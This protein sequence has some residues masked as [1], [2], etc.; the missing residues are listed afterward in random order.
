M[1]RC[2]SWR[3]ARPSDQRP[4]KSR[5]FRPAP[6]CRRHSVQNAAP[7][8]VTLADAT[9][10]ATHARQRRGKPARPVAN[11]GF[12]RAPHD[13]PGLPRLRLRIAGL[14]ET[15]A[16]GSRGLNSRVFRLR[17]DHHP[18]HR[19]ESRH[20]GALIRSACRDTQ[21][22]WITTVSMNGSPVGVC[23]CVL[24]CDLEVMDHDDCPPA[25]RSGRL[26]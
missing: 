14:D 13:S 2:R 6:P 3:L 8:R 24:H 16:A 5:Q 11:A 18:H 20:A 26:R 19:E 17:A 10:T 22:S 25:A 9:A 21:V 4:P 12:H 15:Q 23:G 7:R 1:G